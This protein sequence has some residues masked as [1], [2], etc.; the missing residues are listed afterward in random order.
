[1]NFWP[2]RWRGRRTSGLRLHAV[3]YFCCHRFFFVFCFFS[4]SCRTCIHT[5]PPHG[6]AWCSCISWVHVN[7]CM[8]LSVEFI[9]VELIS[10]G[11]CVNPSLSLMV[12]TAQPTVCMYVFM[13]YES[14]EMH[15]YSLYVLIYSCSTWPLDFC[16]TSE[17]KVEEMMNNVTRRVEGN[18]VTSDL[19][20]N[21]IF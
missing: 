1:M 8:C 12:H 17:G 2:S 19:Q 15:I 14:C 20:L 16:D 11:G 21:Q 10:L 3:C 4:P 18:T 5:H 9:S 7:V 13:H 6:H